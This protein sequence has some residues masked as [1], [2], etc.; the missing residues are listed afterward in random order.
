MP[1]KKKGRR[2]T[3]GARAKADP[4]TALKNAFV[5]GFMLGLDTAQRIRT[6]AA[7]ALAKRGI[8]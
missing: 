8:R 6:V 4:N 2:S 3:R 5:E 1:R 7:G